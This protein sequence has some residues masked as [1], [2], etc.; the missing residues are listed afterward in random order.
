MKDRPLSF[1]YCFNGLILE[2]LRFLRWFWFEAKLFIVFKLCLLLYCKSIHKSL[3]LFW[4]FYSLDSDLFCLQFFELIDST[5][6]HI[7]SYSLGLAFWRTYCTL[8]F[9]SLLLFESYL[10]LFLSL[11]YILRYLID[12]HTRFKLLIRPSVPLMKALEE[13]AQYSLTLLCFFMSLWFYLGL[14]RLRHSFILWSWLEFTSQIM[15]C[16]S[17]T[18]GMAYPTMN[19]FMIFHLSFSEVSI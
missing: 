12:C 5:L 14:R 6:D 10:L 13:L 16:K 3:L 15:H 11:F 19:A 4:S 9:E 17:P 18:S 1:T 8:G 7:L 2:F